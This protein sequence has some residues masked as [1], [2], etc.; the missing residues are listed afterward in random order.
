M[1]TMQELIKYLEAIK[2]NAPESAP[3]DFS[4]GFAKSLL[5]K[6]KQQI[7]KSVNDTIDAYHFYVENPH[8][9]PPM[10]GSD[11]YNSTYK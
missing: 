1:T 11:Y 5:E 2:E 6:E 8:N 10:N 4:I 9:P 7:I 3:L